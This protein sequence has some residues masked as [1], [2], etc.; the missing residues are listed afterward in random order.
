MPSPIQERENIDGAYCNS[1]EQRFPFPMTSYAKCTLLVENLNTAVRM[2]PCA[3][4]NLQ[5]RKSQTDDAY[6]KRDALVNP[7]LPTC[8]K[9]NF[10]HVKK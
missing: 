1:P 4:T 2:L 5:V 8:K 3:L 10:D 7:V 6:F 9:W